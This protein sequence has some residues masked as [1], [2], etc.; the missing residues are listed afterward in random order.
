MEFNTINI[1]INCCGFSYKSN[2]K[3]VQNILDNCPYEGCEKKY[4]CL[5]T[6]VVYNSVQNVFD[7]IE[8]LQNMSYEIYFDIKVVVNN[9]NL[10]SELENKNTYDCV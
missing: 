1:K 10:Y 7:I 2:I 5:V 9:S 8:F 3:L 4:K 6:L